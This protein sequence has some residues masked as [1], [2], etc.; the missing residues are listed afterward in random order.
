M[1]LGVCALLASDSAI[2]RIFTGRQKVAV[3]DLTGGF[4]N[5][6]PYLRF[7]EGSIDHWVWFFNPLTTE[8][9][10]ADLSRSAWH[11]FSS[12]SVKG[13]WAVSHYWLQVAAVDG[14][15]C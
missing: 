5:S 14:W 15:I 4:S 9:C 13:G 10:Q 1:L 12:A 11:R 7:Q 8:K 3:F 2:K 6:S